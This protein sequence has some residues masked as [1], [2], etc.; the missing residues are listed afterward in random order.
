MF[1]NAIY[2]S[3]LF[4]V[5]GAV[6]KERH[7]FELEKL[8]GLVAY[9]PLTFFACLIFSLSISGIPP[10]NGFASKWMIYQGA[11]AGLFTTTSK[12]MGFAY[13]FA[14]IAAM[15]GSALTLASFVKF[16]HAL[17]LG[18]DNSQGKT[19]T[20]ESPLGMLIPLLTL[21]LLCILL[22]LF[23]MAFINNFIQPW[24]PQAQM[25]FMGYWNSPLAFGLITL[26][27]LLGLLSWR[28]MKNKR[29]RQ[30]D[31]FIG[32]ETDNFGTS[33]P[34]TEFYRTIE[35]APRINKIYH[36]ITLERLDIYTIL[37]S[38]LRLI[39][40]LLL[41]ITWPVLLLFKII[42]RRS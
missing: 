28:M 41:I 9:M 24:M 34:A 16:I 27:L 14:L 4:L 23:N 38:A 13:L 20:A 18:Q 33:F 6:E 26:A 17:F 15:F 1:N 19:K 10:L 8:G 30:D 32:G 5:G 22:G 35:A 11:L 3:G 36:F 29:I 7:T 42:K 31:F 39:L 21:A 25:S 37:I 12:A 40:R 2:K